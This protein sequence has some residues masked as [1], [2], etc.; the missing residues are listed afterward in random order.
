MAAVTVTCPRCFADVPADARFCR[1][2]GLGAVSQAAADD[3]MM[4]LDA[5][6]QTLRIG[7]RRAIG[8]VSNIYDCLLTDGTPALVKIARD[9]CAN[10]LLVNE[11]RILRRLREADRAGRFTPFLS[12]I[13]TSFGL[14]DDATSQPRQGT[15]L[16]MH[17]AIHS[18]D[19]LYTL[20]EVRTHFPAGLDPRHVAWIW[21]RLLTILGFAHAQD[22]VHAAV[23]PDHVLIEPRDHKLVLIGWTCAVSSWRTHRSPVAM[24]AGYR[25]W[26]SRLGYLRKPPTPALDIALGATCMIELLGAN[27]AIPAALRR[28]F[29]RCT[30]T[31]LDA[32]Q[33]LRD[34]DR[35]IETLWG[36]RKF[37][38]LDLPPKRRAVTPHAN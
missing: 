29:A 20:D 27:P 4:D 34:F 32:A 6:G 2:C 21:R 17:E 31:T 28:Y 37:M 25:D 7:D 8:S 30:Q 24:T 36:P 5:G 15:V 26:Y 22:T 16:R 12:M 3:A 18:P 1:R 19:E 10:L 23:L 35:L 11:A 14:G 13:V 33:L 9:A 38:T